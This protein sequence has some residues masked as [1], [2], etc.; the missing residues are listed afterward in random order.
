MRGP[1]PL[2]H[3]VATLLTDPEFEG[4]PLK[5]AL[6]QLW[7][8]HHD[9]LGRIERIARVSDGYQSIARERELSLAA[10]FDKQLR[11][12][13]KIARI[14]DRY[15]MMMHDLNASLREASTLDSLTGIANR[16]LLTERLREESERAKR[17]ARPLTLVMLDI[18]R[19][20]VINDEHG[21]EVGDR[22]LIEVVRVMEAEIREQDLCG[23]WGG[24]EF[25]IVMPECTAQTAWAVMRRLGDSIAA[26]GVR[27]NDELLGVTASMG[28]A[29]LHLDETYSSTINRADIA[30][31]RAKRSGRN[32]C[33]L[34]E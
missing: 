8:A 21:H 11:Q 15:Q 7:G 5:E 34:S 10:R 4:H 13:E 12:L 22:V 3:E 33:E 9:L 25:L 19:F 17:Y 29:E 31:L 30:L 18:D 16:R 20:K 23:R 2:E 1:S 27:V 26:L 32:R 24:E 6:S 28:V 14:S